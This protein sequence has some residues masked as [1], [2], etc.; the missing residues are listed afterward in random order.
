MFINTLNLDGP[1]KISKISKI[2]VTLLNISNS[3]LVGIKLYWRIF[4]HLAQPC[5]ARART[6]ARSQD[7]LSHS[8]VFPAF[9]FFNTSSLISI[10]KIDRGKAKKKKHPIICVQQNQKF[11]CNSGP[12]KVNQKMLFFEFEIWKPGK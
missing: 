5:A 11:V 3:K 9:Q 2:V 10:S 7:P 4:C 6:V 12:I 1:F 8:F